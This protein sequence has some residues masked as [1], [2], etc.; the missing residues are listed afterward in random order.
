MDSL[1]SF[2]HWLSTH[3]FLVC[4]LNPHNGLNSGT[5]WAP[6]SHRTFECSP[7][8]ME[9]YAKNIQQCRKLSQCDTKLSHRYTSQYWETDS[10]FSD[11]RNF[12]E[13]RKNAMLNKETNQQAKKKMYDTIS[14]KLWRQ[15]LGYNSQNK[16]SYLSSA[17]M[18]LQYTFWY[19]NIFSKYL[20]IFFD[21]QILLIAQ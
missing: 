10:S 12:N 20:W 5:L 17:A 7:T 1:V 9:Q 13:K 15:V 3:I 16:I 14:K 4:K 18:N 6:I 2:L 19:I 21:I 8:D 11:G